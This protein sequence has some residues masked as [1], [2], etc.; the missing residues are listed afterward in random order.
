VVQPEVDPVS[1]YRVVTTYGWGVKI[2]TNIFHLTI[3]LQ[4][5]ALAAVPSEPN[6]TEAY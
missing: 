1:W 2:K 5:Q 6:E 3:T 4:L